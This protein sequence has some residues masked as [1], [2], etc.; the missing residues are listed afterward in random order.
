M[1]LNDL[2]RM[3]DPEMAKILPKTIKLGG[4]IFLRDAGNGLLMTCGV[5]AA[6]NNKL[7]CET[8]YPAKVEIYYEIGEDLTEQTFGEGIGGILQM[9]VWRVRG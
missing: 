2:Y 1:D 4:Q 8:L 7:P 3:V 5:F 9:P 6:P